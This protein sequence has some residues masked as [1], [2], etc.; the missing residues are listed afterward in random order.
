M[1]QD[2]KSSRADGTRCV[3]PSPAGAQVVP[4]ILSTGS[5]VSGRSTSRRDMSAEIRGAHRL[6]NVNS[7]TW[8]RGRGM[9]GIVTRERKG[10]GTIC[11]SRVA[12]KVCPSALQRFSTKVHL[13]KFLF[14]GQFNWSSFGP[15][16]AKRPHC[17]GH[18][19]ACTVL[20]FYLEPRA[21]RAL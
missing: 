7:H 8:V 14:Q 12:T 11:R 15:K 1:E 9:R 21:C 13:C 17:C 4:H 16:G 18:F 19:R 6:V 3:V 5:A 2:N 10:K 20:C